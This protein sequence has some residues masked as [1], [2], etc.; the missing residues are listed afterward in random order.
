MLSGN[1]HC[2]DECLT[3]DDTD[4][5][6]GLLAGGALKTVRVNK[7]TPIGEEGVGRHH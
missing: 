4:G 1:E 5:K 6:A 3:A 7:K 2:H